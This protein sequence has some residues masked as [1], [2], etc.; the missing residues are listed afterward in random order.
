[1]QARSDIHTEERVEPMTTLPLDDGLHNEKVVLG[2]VLIN[3]KL[4][5]EAAS[6]RANDFQLRGHQLIFSRLSGL[7]HRGIPL[8]VATLV[9]ELGKHGELEK[10][11]G[12]A[13]LSDLSDQTV[14]RS[15]IP[16]HV[17][18]VRKDAQRRELSKL[19]TAIAQF[20]EQGTTGTD[21]LE[22]LRDA[23]RVGESYQ[24]ENHTIRKLSDIPKLL[25]MKVL[26]VEWLVEDLIPCQ[27]LAVVTGIGGSLKSVLLLK[28]AIAVATGGTFLGK[29]CVRRPVLIIDYENTV[30]SAQWRLRQMCGDDANL[31]I[32]GKWCSVP[33]PKIIEGQQLLLEICKASR[34]LLII[35]PLRNGHSKNEDSSTEMLPV[36]EALDSFIIAGATVIVT[37]HLAKKDDS[38]V[39]GTVSLFDRADMFFKQTRDRSTEVVTL[40]CKKN[41]TGQESTYRLKFNPETFELFDSEIQS[42][43]HS[44]S[45]QDEADFEALGRI[46]GSRAGNCQTQVL[47]QWKGRKKRGIELLKKGITG[48][49]WKAHKQGRAVIYEL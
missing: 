43:N 30:Q 10:A 49:R 17:G 4:W 29:R 14:V 12:Y 44:T 40:E 18:L 35:D 11:G 34:P 13:Y 38:F 23:V 8:E 45:D 5:P 48:N 16:Y 27:Q 36:L 24:T 2:S 19:A 33:P 32:W 7:A 25:T 20:G 39:R 41:R 37:H 6:L 1:M 31:S 42:P 47:K 22:H 21:L 15:S 9:E 28:L 46:I 26:P 3:P